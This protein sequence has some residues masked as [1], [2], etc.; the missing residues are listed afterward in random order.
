MVVSLHFRANRFRFHFGR[1][2]N[3]TI[4]SLTLPNDVPEWAKNSN[5]PTHLGN[6]T[7]AAEVVINAAAWEH[8]KLPDLFNMHS[9][10][11]AVRRDL[12]RGDTPFVT[13]SA[14]NNGISAHIE[15][16]P[17]WGGGQITIASNGSVG[18]AFYQPRPFSASRD[19][20]ILEPKFDLTATAALF[21]CAI[22]RKESSRFNYAR[23]WTMGRM[24]ETTIRLPAHSGS[25][26]IQGMEA[27]IRAMPLGWTLAD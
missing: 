2:A 19:V 20:T 1:Q 13:A 14:W 25:L 27:M 9:G 22:L 5:L 11:Y 26:D 8:F 24:K 16:E 17:D 6:N 23:K 15:D 12:A 10:E 3:R 21:I 7:N 18:A 4:S